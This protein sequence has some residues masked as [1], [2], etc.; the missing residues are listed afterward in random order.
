MSFGK[1]ENSTLN[2]TNYQLQQIQNTNAV[3]MTAEWD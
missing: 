3:L 1:N 2:S